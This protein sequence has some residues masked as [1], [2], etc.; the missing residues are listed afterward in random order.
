VFDAAFQAPRCATAARSCDT[1]PS[2][3]RGRAALG[4][5]PNQPNTI[6]DGCADGTAGAFHVD[7]SVDRLVV[8]TTDGTAFAPGKTV[9]I[10]ATVWAWTTPSADA[11]DLYYAANATSP[12]WTFIGTL[13]P[14]AAGEQTLSAAYTLPAGAIQAVRAQFRYQGAASPCGSGSYHDRDDVVFAVGGP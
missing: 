2:L 12:T 7:E 10:D 3:V 9:R 5:E 14:A 4:P 6:Q 11:L 1:G 8:S 13:A